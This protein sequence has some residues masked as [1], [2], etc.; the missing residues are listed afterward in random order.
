MNTDDSTFLLLIW[1]RDQSQTDLIVFNWIR[2]IY[3]QTYFFTWPRDMS[4][5]DQLVFIFYWTGISHWMVLLIL[6][7]SWDTSQMDL[8]CSFRTNYVTHSYTLLVISHKDTSHTDL[9]TSHWTMVFVTF[10]AIYFSLTSLINVSHRPPVLHL[11]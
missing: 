10:W 2:A 3:W 4:Q 11:I 8:H 6:T 5:T 9:F 1:P 7:W